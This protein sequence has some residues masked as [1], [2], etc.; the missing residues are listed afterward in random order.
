MAH[1]VGSEKLSVIA[2]NKK[3]I[4][5]IASDHTRPVPSKYIIP[6]MLKEIRSTAPDALITILIATGCHRETTKEEVDRLLE[7]I[8]RILQWKNR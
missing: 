5:I 4:V 3:N 8:H 7:G 1:P 6:P 2:K